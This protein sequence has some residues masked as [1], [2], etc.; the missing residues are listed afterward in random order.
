M[1]A[2]GG[3]IYIHTFLISVIERREWPVLYFCAVLPA[4][5]HW[6]QLNR[7][8]VRDPGLNTLTKKK[9]CREL[10]PSHPVCNQLLLF[11][12]L[13]RLIVYSIMQMEG[14]LST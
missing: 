6:N 5:S 9:P 14:A 3:E 11:A 12:E 7:T 8:L 1:K 10:K 4:D 13:S 2:Y